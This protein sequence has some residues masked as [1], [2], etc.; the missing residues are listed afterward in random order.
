MSKLSVATA[1][2]AP[3]DSGAQPRPRARIFLRRLA[4]ASTA[5]VLGA[6]LALVGIAAPASAH[7][8]TISASAA[9]ASDGKT[10][11]ITWSVTNSENLEETITSSSLEEVVPQGTTI[12]KKA[13]SEFVQ[14]GAKLEEKQTLTLAAKWS[15]DYM[16]T[17]SASFTAPYDLCAGGGGGNDKIE[18]CHSGNGKK[19]VKIETAVEAFY[20]S[21]HIDH[22]DDIFPAFSFWKHGNLIQVAAQGDQSL[23]Q[24]PDCAL[25]VVP[26]G[27]EPTFVD[28]CGADNEELDVPADTATIAW[29][30]EEVDGKWIVTATAIN[31][32]EFPDGAKT[33]WEFPIDDEPCAEPSLAGS[34]A[35][36]ECEADVPWIFYDVVLTGAD[37]TPGNHVARLILT[38][39]TNTE[40]L[41][42]GELDENGKL[43]GR[44]LWPGAAVDGEGN[45][46]AWPGWE[47]LSDGTW[48]ETDG[49]Y[50]WTRGDISAKLV[51]NPE[52]PVALAYPPAT[53][54]C[55]TG[56]GSGDAHPVALTSTGL[57]STGF[58]GTTIA[59]VAGVIVIA[60]VAFVVIARI[61]R[62]RA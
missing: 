29:T 36:G 34:L 11:D 54:D 39:G 32:F 41:E 60:G 10:A 5:F 48:V 13:T 33:S 2:A 47:Q 44:V 43:T 9:C 21:G 58:A 52:I 55:L 16:Q 8:N 7:H 17:N 18:Y 28:D 35:V 40:E 59:I 57:A 45:P 51:V 12:G 50:A 27:G 42:L 1:P 22:D 56:P 15:N 49:N 26:V 20:E 3:E 23:L 53:P 14:K 25:E 6:G 30:K 19:Y 46:T 4:A 37:D 24:Y 31:G 62:K 61:R 38:D